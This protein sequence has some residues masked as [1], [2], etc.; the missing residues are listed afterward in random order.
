MAKAILNLCRVCKHSQV[1]VF[2]PPQQT[3]LVGMQPDVEGL[4]CKPMVSILPMPVVAC[5]IFEKGTPVEQRKLTELKDLV[6][7]PQKP[8]PKIVAV[9][10]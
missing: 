1:V 5:E 6:G 10:N 8:G 4:H 9:H 2:H 7:Q 3:G